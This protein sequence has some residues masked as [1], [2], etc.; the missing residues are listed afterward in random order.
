MEPADL[1]GL[2]RPEKT[3]LIRY[4]RGKKRVVFS[5][6]VIEMRRTAASLNRDLDLLAKYELIRTYKESEHGHRVHKIIEP[7]FGNQKIEL[8]AEI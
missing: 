8:K 2:L 5:D 6:L 3:E 7:V 1:P 4:L